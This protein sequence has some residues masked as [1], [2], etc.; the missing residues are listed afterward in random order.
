MIL[1][2]IG[3]IIAIICYLPGA[4]KVFKTHDTRGISLLMFVM[5]SFGCL[6]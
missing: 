6:I 1:A 3:S 4:I 2:F 5:T